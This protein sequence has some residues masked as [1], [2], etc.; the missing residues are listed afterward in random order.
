MRKSLPE[1]QY[2]LHWD[3]SRD[4]KVC[5][6][7]VEATHRLGELTLFSDE[8]IAQFM[9]Q[10]PRSELSIG[11][12][13]DNP[14]HPTQWQ[15]GEI[16][17]L[18]GAELLLAIRRGRL[19]LQLCNL[20]RHP[21]AIGQT[22]QRLCREVMECQVD[23]QTF[24]HQGQLLI[25]SPSALQY[26]N[27]GIDPSILWQIRGT[28]RVWV[29]PQGGPFLPARTMEQLVSGNLVCTPYYE[30]AFDDQAVV[31]DLEPGQMLALP[32]HTPHRS[33]NLDGL[34]ITLK[35]EYCTGHSV[36][37]NRVLRANDWLRRRL[38]LSLESRLSGWVGEFLKRLCVHGAD[39]RSTRDLTENSGVAARTR[40]EKTFRLD[41]DSAGGMKPLAE[42]AWQPPITSPLLPT[43]IEIPAA[44]AAPLEI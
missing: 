41:S 33:A 16:G 30:P 10:L 22:I 1:P 32:Q 42:D 5:R 2:L 3:H 39:L 17:R 38:P 7:V 8:M 6:D 19:Q 26:Y 25:S 18:H 36:R 20:H 29:Y 43:A 27:G 13:G 4:R 23:L 35:T 24:G 34:N 37:R 31:F 21:S 11:T 12:M 15:L 9:D 44:N 28:K 14:A 40:I